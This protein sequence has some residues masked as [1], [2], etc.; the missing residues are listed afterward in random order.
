MKMTPNDKITRI[1]GECGMLTRLLMYPETNHKGG[2]V[3]VSAQYAM[4]Y[5]NTGV[6]VAISNYTL[7]KRLF[8]SIDECNNHFFSLRPLG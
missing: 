4:F 3:M 5:R 1:L 2:L 7:S 6:D 8:V